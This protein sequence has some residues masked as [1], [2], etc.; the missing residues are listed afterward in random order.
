M[1]TVPQ[2]TP[3]SAAPDPL[4]TTFSGLDADRYRVAASFVN[5]SSSPEGRQ[6]K[7]R[8][9]STLLAARPDLTAGT[10][11]AVS[12]FVNES[13]TLEGRRLK[14]DGLCQVAQVRPL[15]ADFVRQ[16]ATFVNGAEGLE[17]RRP[18]VQALVDFSN[19]RLS[20]DMTLAAARFVGTSTRTDVRREKTSLVDTVLGAG[21]DRALLSAITTFVDES[22]SG[23][24]RMLKCEGLKKLMALRPDIDA[25]FVNGMARLVNGAN[26]LENRRARI[27]AVTSLAAQFPKASVDEL[28]QMSSFVSSSTNTT[29]RTTKVE[30]LQRF[31][32][33][34]LGADVLSA[35]ESF[36]DES[37]SAEGRQLKLGSLQKLVDLN[38]SIS[39]A[40]VSALAGLVN[41]S[42]SIEGR[43]LKL[44]YVE[45][46]FEGRPDLPAAVL[47]GTTAYVNGVSGLEGR[48]TR[49]EHTKSLLERFP[50]VSGEAFEKAASKA[51]AGYSSADAAARMST[52]VP[53][54]QAR[55]LLAEQTLTTAAAGAACTSAGLSMALLQRVEADPAVK[56]AEAARTA[57]DARVAHYAT[58]LD[59]DQQTL[60][61]TERALCNEK[62]AEIGNSY[63]HAELIGTVATVGAGFALA[64]GLPVAANVA[65]LIKV[66]GMALGVMVVPALVKKF[67][68]KRM[69]VRVEQAMRETLEPH[70]TWWQ[71]KCTDLAALREEAR[72]SALHRVFA[73]G[74]TADGTTGTALEAAPRTVE[75]EDEAVIIGGIRVGRRN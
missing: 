1:L 64:A 48:R 61:S 5:E 20:D 34:G 30:A 19:R 57:A 70:R 7:T 17:S 12:A 24:G 36:V 18:R 75:M 74:T 35:V 73:D 39:S 54:L 72:Q 9:L 40:H 50:T 66:A 4:R 25:S 26:G 53:E 71:Q 45:K 29:V 15:T 56:L 6:L 3:P 65:Q 23:E 14:L 49:L 59:H 43:R 28:M 52:F 42:N 13:T 31:T 63:R 32:D 27:E 58:A 22:S 33:A 11:S 2:A 16:A 68:Q 8:A 51:R 41:E 47:R 67:V 60:F 46:L 37:K 55:A 21:G 44:Q 62:W 38:P 69:P 10:L